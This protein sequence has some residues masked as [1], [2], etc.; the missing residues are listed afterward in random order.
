M[1]FKNILLFSV[2]S[3]PTVLDRRYTEVPKMTISSLTTVVS[4]SLVDIFASVEFLDI[5]C[6]IEPSVV[7]G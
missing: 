7:S 1:Y 6:N 2:F 3:V 5:S 4:I